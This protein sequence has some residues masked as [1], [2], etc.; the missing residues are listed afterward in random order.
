MEELDLAAVDHRSVLTLDPSNEENP[1]RVRDTSFTALDVLEM[2]AAD[3][4]RREIVKEFPELKEEDVLACLAYAA[5]RERVAAGK[6][7]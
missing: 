1:V 7:V 4:S 6:E 3:I 2:L 5:H